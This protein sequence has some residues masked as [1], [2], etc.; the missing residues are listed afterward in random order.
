MKLYINY[1]FCGYRWFVINDLFENVE[2]TNIVL[3]EWNGE[4]ILRIIQK[5]MLYDSYDV[6]F[7]TRM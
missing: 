1:N 5:M 3:N 4:D 6:V 2:S 7:F